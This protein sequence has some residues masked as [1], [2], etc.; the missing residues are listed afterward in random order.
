MKRFVLLL[1]AALSLAVSAASPA[2]ARVDDTVIYVG[3]D[4]R[5]MNAAIA[6]ARETLPVFWAWFDQA[7]DATQAAILKVGYPNTRGGLEHIW[8]GNITRKDGVIRGVIS[9]EPEAVPGLAYGQAVIVDPAAIS[10]WGYTKDGKLWG[11]FTTR[12]MVTRMKPDDAQQY[13]DMLSPQ[14]IEPN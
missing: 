1:L 12:V 9:N 7:P 5:E 13:V 2:M 8:V 6:K 10:D 4:D 14:P 3:E 11:N